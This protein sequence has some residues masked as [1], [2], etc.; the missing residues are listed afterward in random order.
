MPRV[1]RGMR[2]SVRAR[3]TLSRYQEVRIRHFHELLSR[4]IGDQRG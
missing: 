3:T 4:Y 2:A 1:Q